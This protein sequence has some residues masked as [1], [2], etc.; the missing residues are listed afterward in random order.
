MVGLLERL[1]PDEVA[2]FQLGAH[3]TGP[4]AGR[5]GIE[6]EADEEAPTAAE[7]GHSASSSSSSATDPGNASVDPLGVYFETLAEKLFRRYDYDNSETI[8]D[9]TELGQ[10]TTNL[11]VKLKEMDPRLELRSLWEID[12]ILAS[13]QLEPAG[14]KAFTLQTFIE[15]FR[16]EILLEPGQLY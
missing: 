15:W 6:L 1:T 12:Q 14:D 2:I 16:R 4:K 11:A 9:R 7:M 8:N 3:A 5:E 13:I 10:L